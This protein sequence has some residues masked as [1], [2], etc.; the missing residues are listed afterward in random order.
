MNFRS[1]TAAVLYAH[2][3]AMS[4]SPAWARPEPAHSDDPVVH[5]MPEVF[6]HQFLT[7]IDG[8][9]TGVVNAIFNGLAEFDPYSKTFPDKIRLHTNVH[10]KRE[11]YDNFNFTGTYT[12]I[13]RFEAKFDASP[14]NGLH[15]LNTAIATPALG[16]PYAS[17]IFTPTLTTKWVNVRQVEPATLK[18]LE[19]PATLET[20][21]AKKA[22]D[23]SVDSTSPSTPPS[24]GIPP[25]ADSK[26][27][28]P[29][30]KNMD[31]LNHAKKR[32]LSVAGLRRLFGAG[33]AESSDAAN[34]NGSADTDGPPNPSLTSTSTST[35]TPKS[36]PTADPDL[37]ETNPYT[38][39]YLVDPSIRARF[40]KIWNPFTFPFRSPLTIKGVRRLDDGEVIAYGVNG[41]VEVGGEVG[42][43]VIPSPGLQEAGLSVKVTAS[44]EGEFQISILK[45]D[46]RF[47]QVKLSRNRKIG[48]SQ[49]AAVSV[50]TNDV[51]KGHLII[52]G[53]G[54][55]L[56]VIPFE[57]TSADTDL[58]QYDV[59]Y[60]YDLHQIA[61][62][63]AY[64]RAV[65][66]AFGRS[67]EL[68]DH[69][70]IARP[71][72]DEVEPIGPA[73]DVNAEPTDGA[74]A[75]Q[76][77]FTRRMKGTERDMVRKF[78]LSFA[79]ASTN[80]KDRSTVTADLEMPDGKHT[81]HRSL[82]LHNIN[83]SGPF[84]NASESISRKITVLMDEESYRAGKDDSLFV[85]AESSFEDSHTK[86][87]ELRAVTDEIE[88]FLNQPNLFP[89][90]P[91]TI[92]DPKKPDRK[93]KAY[94]GQS[95]FYYGV[96]LNRPRVEQFLAVPADARERIVTEAFR[97]R[98]LM[99][100]LIRWNKDKREMLRAWQDAIDANAA[101]DLPRLF[102][103]LT[104]LF[105]NRNR[106]TETLDIIRNV[107]PDNSLDYF[108]TAQNIGFGKIQKSGKI[109]TP[110]DAILLKTDNTLGQETFS[111]RLRTDA[112]A[113]VS[114]IAVNKR[115]DGLFELVFKLA[116]E[117]KKIDFQIT[118][119]TPFKQNVLSNLITLRNADKRF[120]LGE[121][122]VILDPKA[123]E[124]TLEHE[125]GQYLRSGQYYTVALGYSQG[126]AK[127]GPSNSTRIY[128][129][130]DAAYPAI[131]V[132]P[133][134]A[135]AEPLED[136]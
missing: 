63:D 129:P 118:R 81:V 3:L 131:E 65:V 41:R 38:P 135:N 25:V 33:P 68:A 116:R 127:E 18:A 14:L 61:S 101:G 69:P 28:T 95:S 15:T 32:P 22:G 125:L 107:L 53:L 86:P 136:Q 1:V 20:Q 16:L 57:Y 60:R 72:V 83:H 42:W 26:L 59:V 9:K 89:D 19:A 4:T 55:S 100:K 12:V 70:E 96:S 104:A 103:A 29:L 64:L 8:L 99:R 66:G 122:K 44:L 130:G 36:T 24:N 114:E 119:T 31:T 48:V 108:I 113:V 88:R 87:K 109:N 39:F 76:R 11:V 79:L 54:L 93:R 132:A 92:P 77:L 94:Y 128:V 106:A 75:V 13:D 37:S 111:Q 30:I 47:V 43:K 74:P 56:Q 98:S 35:A 73:G 121:N 123:P 80:E 51:L 134:S 84:G 117:P 62:H 7:L 71:A 126:G 97:N 45:E 105:D 115:D 23:A 27:L 46:E 21:F 120:H 2:L 82:A 5:P 52:N 6:R 50:Q 90:F 34:E 110:V 124:R 112:A 102:K 67:A 10:V 58:S 78:K 40:G 85:I 17:V 91:D 49:S 133:L